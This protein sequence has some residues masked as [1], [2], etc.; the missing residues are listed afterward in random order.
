ML[1][2]KIIWFPYYYVF[3]PTMVW[4]L[5]AN[6]AFWAIMLSQLLVGSVL[7]YTLYS[8]LPA[9]A[10]K[11]S[12][13]ARLIIAIWH[14]L[15]RVMPIFECHRF[16]PRRAKM[17][18]LICFKAWQLSPPM[19]LLYKERMVGK[20]GLGD[21]IVDLFLASAI[22]TVIWFLLSAGFLKI[23]FRFLHS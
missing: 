21:R 13:L 19:Y 1:V 6:G 23:L 5:T 11:V 7:F 3:C 9:A 22:S 8:R 18:V 4:R 15:Q 10:E 12:G 14:W 2:D 20:T 17:G 16:I